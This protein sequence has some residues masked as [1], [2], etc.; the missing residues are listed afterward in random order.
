VY[1]GYKSLDFGAT[2]T[3]IQTSVT[4]TNQNW[5]TV[6]VSAS[7]QYQVAA[8]DFT[9]GDYNAPNGGPIYFSS[10]FGGSWTQT[11]APDTNVWTSIS[12]SASGQY[13]TAVV[14]NGSIYVSSTA[15]LGGMTGGTVSTTTQLL[16]VIISGVTYYLQ[17]Y[18]S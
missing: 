17:L 3:A 13:I 14:Q 1:G 12:I 5:Q 7:G 9:N 18:S 15:N 16:S 4:S 2:W 8:I 10:D 11:P 6:S